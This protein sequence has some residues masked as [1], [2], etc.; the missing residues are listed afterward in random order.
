M[1]NLAGLRQVPVVRRNTMIRLL[2][3]ILP[4]IISCN[5][6]A[7]LSNKSIRRFIK[8]EY[9]FDGTINSQNTLQMDLRDDQI[10]LFFYFGIF[11]MPP[12]LPEQLINT[13]YK[14]KTIEIWRDEN[15]K[16]KYEANWVHTFTYDSLSRLIYF[17]YSS[18][19]QC[20]DISYG[21]HLNYN[22]LNQIISIENSIKSNDS[23]KIIYDSSGI[24]TQIDC[25]STFKSPKG[26]Y[27]YTL[28]KRVEKSK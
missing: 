16:D 18:C 10:G 19:L 26:K 23:Y 20:S 21:Y 6:Y 12:H 13:I 24:I 5:S 27:F 2:V 17:G 8:T 1:F 4:L 22:S 15:A 3:M 11:K 7:Q 28:S 14:N 25:F 9:L